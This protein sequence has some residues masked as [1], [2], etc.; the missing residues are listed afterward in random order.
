MLIQMITDTK[1]AT[2][3]SSR[4]LSS[5]KTCFFLPPSIRT[6]LIQKFTYLTTSG[7]ALHSQN[8]QQFHFKDSL[9]PTSSSGCTLCQTKLK[10]VFSSRSTSPP[11]SILSTH[12]TS[13]LLPRISRTSPVTIFTTLARRGEP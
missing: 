12:S 9:E 3:C 6:L 7:K 5:A 13:L 1:I 11:S 4:T 10:S 8:L 2:F